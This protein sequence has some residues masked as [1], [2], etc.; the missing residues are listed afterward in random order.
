VRSLPRDRAGAG[1]ADMSEAHT[2]PAPSPLRTR[3]EQI[4]DELA[5]EQRAPEPTIRRLPDEAP[6][7]KPALPG[8]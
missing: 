5:A 3:A 7:V 1:T 6:A 8:R 2:R 4:A